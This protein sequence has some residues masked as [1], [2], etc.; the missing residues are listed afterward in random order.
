MSFTVDNM[1]TRREIIRSS[2]IGTAFGT[3]TL[4]GSSSV[5][6]AG[7]SFSDGVNL[8]PSYY[9]NGEQDLGWNL[10]RNYSDIQTVRIEIEPPSWGEGQ[11]DL[12]EIRRWIDEANANGYH[13]FAT[14]H[15][16][17]NNGSSDSQAL[18]DA[19]NW[20]ATNYSYL[21]ANSSFTINVM[22]EWGDHNVSA[23][24]YAKAYNNAISTVRD[25]TSYTG[26]LVCDIPGWGQETH[27]AADA[28]SN[29]NDNNI[30][31]SAHLYNSAYNQDQGSWLQP[32]HLEYLNSNPS[33]YRC[34]VGEFGSEMD[35]QADWS[36]LVD[37]A[38]SLGWPVLG[39][40]WN[41]DGSSPP[42]NMVSPSWGDN[43]GA[44]SY[45]TASYFDTVYNKLGG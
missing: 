4:T 17:P 21:S 1:L 37:H 40:A 44:A 22:N 31:F 7:A 29:I 28:S 24:Q 8:Q 38:K 19:A 34:M 23:S 35:G 32:S 15:H 27:V 5:T 11:A 20:W 39:W 2:V 43:C 6:A 41:G 10:M 18:Y 45:S 36:A 14:C 3:G 9:C 42:M 13:V 33:G 30:I 12:G 26:P 25:G 16:W